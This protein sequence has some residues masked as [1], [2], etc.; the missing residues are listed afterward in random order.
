MAFNKGFSLLRK[1]I[2][3][4]Y[5]TMSG[6][7]IIGSS[8]VTKLVSLN[9]DVL[10]KVKEE[11]SFFQKKYP[12]IKVKVEE[13]LHEVTIKFYALRVSFSFENFLESF[14]CDLVEVLK[15]LLSNTDL[16]IRLNIYGEIDNRKTI[17][18]YRYLNKNS[19][20]SYKITNS[21]T[22]VSFLT[23]LRHIR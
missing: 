7:I 4:D 6:E 11:A 3:P 9:S 23:K 2:L 5:L 18:S 21:E 1:L 16:S 20:V 22:K 19:E 8:D 14:K 17:D 15:H 12:Y 13:G 10:T